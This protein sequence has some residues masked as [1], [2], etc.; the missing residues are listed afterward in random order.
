MLSDDWDKHRNDKE[1]HSRNENP[2]NIKERTKR[3]MVLGAL[4][5]PG[6]IVFML[7]TEI[8]SSMF[9]SKPLLP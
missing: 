5:I 3:I 7:S 1:Y 4:S 9:N 8:I 6:I 2:F